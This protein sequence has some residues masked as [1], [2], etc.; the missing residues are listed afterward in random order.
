MTELLID[1]LQ[2]AAESRPHDMCAGGFSNAEMWARSGAVA[3]WLIARNFGRSPDPIRV[4]PSADAARAVFL[5]GALRAAM[6]VVIASEASP[7]ELDGVPFAALAR[8]SIDAAVAE[9]RLHIGAE[10]P[11]QMRDGVCLC[12]GDLATLDLALA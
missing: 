7:L 4:G 1:R 9:R 6:L 10:T 2:A 12:H 8:C 3:S 5:L 11:A